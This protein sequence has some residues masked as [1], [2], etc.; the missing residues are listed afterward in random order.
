MKS[1]T[2]SFGCRSEGE[3]KTEQSR[4]VRPTWLGKSFTRH[5]KI[6]LYFPLP[7]TQQFLT[8]QDGMQK[9]TTLNTQAVEFSFDHHFDQHVFGY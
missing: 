1:D 4:R 8:K 7:Q 5:Q 3:K 6:P 2:V 9:P